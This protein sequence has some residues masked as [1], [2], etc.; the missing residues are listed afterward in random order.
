MADNIVQLAMEITADPSKAIK[1]IDEVNATAQAMQ[2]TIAQ[3]LQMQGASV[4]QAAQVYRQLGIK[5]DQAAQKISGAFGEAGV[6]AEA[7][8]EKAQASSAG[9]MASM[10]EAIAPLRTFRMLMYSTFGL[11]SFGFYISEWGRVV[12]AIQEGISAMEGFD[13]A[14]QKAFADIVKGAGEA[15]VYFQ[16]LTLQQKIWQG[17]LL[18]MQTQQRINA[19]IAARQAIQ[20][21]LYWHNLLFYAKGV[22]DLFS[23]NPAT[24]AALGGEFNIKAGALK[25]E[26]QQEALLAKQH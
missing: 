8:D 14:A 15:L 22:F 1:G 26:L 7:M 5:G 11:I 20:A 12:Q 19:D 2:R 10:R 23:A 21:Q 6:A 17:Q 9:I 24:L 18:E 4:E 3:S 13:G 16:G 25:D